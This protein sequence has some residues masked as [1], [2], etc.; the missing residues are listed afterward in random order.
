VVSPAQIRTYATAEAYALGHL[1]VAEI[2]A[3][4]R[5]AVVARVAAELRIP[6]PEVLQTLARDW[7]ETQGRAGQRV[8]G[9][10]LSAASSTTPRAAA[11]GGGL[12]TTA[13]L[14]AR[15]R[16]LEPKPAASTKPAATSAATNTS[17]TPDRVATRADSIDRALR[18]AT[19]ARVSDDVPYEQVPFTMR[20]MVAM[21]ARV[22]RPGLDGAPDAKVRTGDYGAVVL[23]KLAPDDPIWDMPL[24]RGMGS[25]DPA[26]LGLRITGQLVPG[27]TSNDYESFKTYSNKQPLDAFEWT[28]D[29]FV[30]LKGAG[31]HGY[32][33]RTTL[34]ELAD[35]GVRDVARK[36]GDT[37]GG[38]FIEGRH[39]PV[40]RSLGHVPGQYVLGAELTPS[41]DPRAAR[42]AELLS[43]RVPEQGGYGEFIDSGHDLAKPLLLQRATELS[44]QVGFWADR[45]SELDPSSVAPAR[46]RARLETLAKEPDVAERARELRKLSD[47][48]KLRVAEVAERPRDDVLDLSN[49]QP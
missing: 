26:I 6:E 5:A 34:R 42:Y 43:K 37:E 28:L 4:Q 39:R 2:P 9:G 1:T 46:A 24:Y 11:T 27:G 49:W 33:L 35:Q 29:P 15:Q 8:A 14:A 25:S 32:L 22:V 19:A 10:H 23:A 31:G 38:F 17:A 41:A 30:A 12:S 36:V 47:G 45:L 44:G 20:R 48:L 16:Q 3:P 13:L 21:D 18:G 7:N 40:A